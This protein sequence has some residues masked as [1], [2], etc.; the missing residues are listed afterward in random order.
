LLRAALLVDALEAAARKCHLATSFQGAIDRLGLVVVVT[1]LAKQTASPEHL[2]D[3][4][5][6]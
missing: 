2:A 6:D 4:L 3:A 5:A 1:R